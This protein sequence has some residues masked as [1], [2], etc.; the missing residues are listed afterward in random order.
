[1]GHDL[2][3]VFITG[4]DDLFIF[5]EIVR[6]I[7]EEGAEVVNASFSILG[8]SI[9]HL[10]HPK[11]GESAFNFGAARISE[12]LKVLVHGNTSEVESK[13]ELWD[14]DIQPV[15]WEFEIPQVMHMGI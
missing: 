7:L 11:I 4:L 6:M 1:M 2:D 10:V 5:Y 13:H 8:N 9:L 12:R 15:T 3:V 14:F